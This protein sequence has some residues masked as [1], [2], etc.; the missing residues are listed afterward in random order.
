MPVEPIK[1]QRLH[2]IDTT[3]DIREALEARVK[4]PLWF[5]ARQ[6]QTGE[7]EA[8]NGG[9]PVQIHADAEEYAF[10][11]LQFA[12]G[13]GAVVDPAVPLDFLIEAETGGS[14]PSAPAWNALALEYEFGLSAR[15]HQFAASEY[16][17]RALDWH[18]FGLTRQHGS[19]TP[20]GAVTS[21]TMIPNRLRFPG[22]PDPRWWAFEEGD[23]Y[24]DTP[25]DPEP[26]IL[27][28]L[29]P[30]FS[31]VDVDNWYLI[32]APMRAGSLRKIA[33]LRVIDSFGVVTPLDPIV[34]DRADADWAMFAIDGQGQ[35]A[36][37]DGS[38]L[39]APNVALQVVEN[40]EVEEVRFLRDESAN[41]VWAWERQIEGPDGRAIGTGNDAA[42][43]GGGPLATAG[44]A[45]EFRLTSETARAWIPYV[46]RQ[47][48]P[49]PA[50]SGQ[51]VLRRG[52]TDAQASDA[53][54]Q[55]RSLIVKE[56]RIVAEEQIPL[57]PLRVR[58]VHRYAIGSDGTA[59]FWIGRDREITT[60]TPR[61]GLRFDYLENWE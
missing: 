46:P 8:E 6:W 50:L 13:G 25:E 21:M 47:I 61:P 43:A 51:I 33:A 49:Q 38:V 27:S 15:G 9:R 16:D 58:R 14:T 2:A 45:P 32:P 3:P 30:E 34:D 41:L 59:H 53:A 12:G 57:T 26:N 42:A 48:D 5:L 11:A 20:P 19:A 23:A 37:L 54:P 18:D 7:F 55:Y 56:A 24:F 17:G 10:E 44:G 28:M 52:R 22:S 36:G 40:D 60:S 31:F 39:M 4:D 35:T 29:L 1:T